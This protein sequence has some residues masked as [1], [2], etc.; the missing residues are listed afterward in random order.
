[1]S[2][3]SGQNRSLTSSLELTISEKTNKL[4]EILEIQQNFSKI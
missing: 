1:M 3:N 2:S 4:K